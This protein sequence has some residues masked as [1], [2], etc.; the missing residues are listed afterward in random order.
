MKIAFT[1]WG[2]S[3]LT[4]LFFMEIY[5][6]H[7]PEFSGVIN[8]FDSMTRL[9]FNDDAIGLNEKMRAAEEIHPFTKEIAIWWSRTYQFISNIFM[10]GI[11]PAIVYDVLAKNTTTKRY[12]ATIIE[13]LQ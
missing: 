7:M 12:L 8:S 1:F 3:I 2:F 4:T 11:P 6:H 10:I 5:S 13:S 9:F